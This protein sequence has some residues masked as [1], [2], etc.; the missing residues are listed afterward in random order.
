[1]TKIESVEDERMRNPRGELLP[2]QANSMSVGEQHCACS[3]PGDEAIADGRSQGLISWL[4]VSGAAQRLRL[5]YPTPGTSSPLESRPAHGCLA[6]GFGADGWPGRRQLR[7]FGEGGMTLAA[8]RRPCRLRLFRPMFSRHERSGE[9]TQLWRRKRRW[10]GAARDSRAVATCFL[11]FAFARGTHPAAWKAI[12]VR[13]EEL[14]GNR[15]QGAADR[16]R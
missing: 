13:H 14:Q 7:Q 5:H 10:S 8:G 1:M 9:R 3:K 6:A 4:G 2:A 15:F 11:A 16:G 12:G